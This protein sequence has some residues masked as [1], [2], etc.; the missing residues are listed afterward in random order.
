[1]SDAGRDRPSSTG[2]SSRL[3]R[4]FFRGLFD[5]GILTESGVESYTRVIIGILAA[6]FV[7]GLFLTRLYASKYGA[8]SAAPGAQPYLQALAAD[9]TFAVAVPMWIVAFVTVLV[10]HSLFPD[11][12]DFR[13][14]MALPVSRGLIFGAKLRAL[15]CFAGLFTGTASVAMVPLVTLMSAGRWADHR[16]VARLLA[17]LAASGAGSVFAALAVVSVSGGLALLAP[18]ARVA[19]TMAAARSATLCGLV[20]LLPLVARFP[21]FGPAYAE[22]APSLSW[23]PPVWFV[24][25]E[26]TLLGE[27]DDFFADLGVQAVAALIVAGVA[28]LATY[29]H[30]YRRFDRVML[31][32]FVTPARPPIVLRLRLDWRS[33][34][35]GFS[36]VRAFVVATLGRSALHQGTVIALS[37]CGG[38][39]VVNS[40]VSAGITSWMSGHAPERR[41]V[42]AAMWAPFV[43]VFVGTM[44]VRASM[45]LPIERRANWVF[46]MTE[47]DDTRRGQLEA[48][49]YAMVRFG[50][51]LPLLLLLPLQLAVAG[52]RALV[53]PVVAGSAGLLMAEILLRDWR[54]IPFTCSYLPGKRSVTY[55]VVTAFT[56]FTFFS[57]IGWLLTLGCLARPQRAAYVVTVLGIPALI[58]RQRRVKTWRTV[59]LLFEDR[60]PDEPEGLGLSAR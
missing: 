57:T 22:R 34:A 24:G 42:E 38:A 46:R 33:Q 4:H 12:T 39:L 55:T 28:A 40:F 29:V 49:H 47:R 25:L 44:A 19:R 32:S 10:S 27:D 3:A 8:L 17:Y 53:A 43:L 41:L 48:A 52:S 14:L 5:L 51:A 37:A 15:G 35:P 56:A 59:P 7:C 60:F 16:I 11:E 21:A 2:S 31:R 30:A 58:L 9:D 1:M 6:I 36:A 20:L 54:R 18:K 45:A 50:I 13:V 26:R 23:L